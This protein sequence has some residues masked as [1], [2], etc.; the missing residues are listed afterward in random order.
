[1]KKQFR[2]LFALATVLALALTLAACGGTAPSAAAASSAPPAA[3]SAKASSAPASSAASA[4]A[5]SSAAGQDTENLAD[6][7]TEEQVKLY[8]DARDAYLQLIGFDQDKGLYFAKGG[9]METAQNGDVTYTLATGEINTYE[10]FIEYMNSLFTEECWKALTAA[11]ETYPLFADFDGKLGILDGGRG[12]NIEYVGPDL[13]RLA[14]SGNEGITF[15]V[16]GQYA[17]FDTSDPYTT[18]FPI[19]MVE[20]PSGWRINMFNLTY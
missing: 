5:S 17:N 6:F 4:P 7:L 16:I 3:S 20:T 9:Q 2:S 13:Y 10:G 19:Q 18:E 15:M 12:A 1:M 8:N 11:E 14:Y